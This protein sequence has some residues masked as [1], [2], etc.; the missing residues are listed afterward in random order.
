MAVKEKLKGIYAITP[1]KFD[2]DKLFTDI[3]SCLSGGITVFQIR[4]KQKVSHSKLE[5]FKKIVDLIHSQDAICFF[6][7][8]PKIAQII[9]ADGVHLGQKDDAHSQV[10]K[11]YPNLLTGITCKDSLQLAKTAV[12]EKADY[13]SFGAFNKSHTKLEA[14][15]ITR[16]KLNQITAFQFT[17]KVIIGGINQ[18]NFIEVSRLNFDMIAICNAIFAASD[19]E[20]AVNFFVKHFNFE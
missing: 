8:S 18:S 17:K 1:E 4:Y 16:K 10:R 14:K 3:S 19:V 6:N 12:D 7:D 20:Q 2:E 5:Y 9:A 11:E 13:V 15:K